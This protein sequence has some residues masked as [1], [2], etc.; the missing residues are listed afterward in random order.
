MLKILVIVGICVVLGF[1]GAIFGFF[2]RA[3]GS[4]ATDG[5]RFVSDPIEYTGGARQVTLEDGTVAY[6]PDVDQLEF[7]SEST[8]QTIGLGNPS[9]NTDLYFTI[10]LKLSGQQLLK[11]DLLHPGEGI[12]DEDLSAIFKPYT[13]SAEVVY[14]FYRHEDDGK[15]V[16]FTSISQPIIINVTGGTE[17]YDEQ[18]QQHMDQTTQSV[19]STVTTTTVDSNGN[20]VSSNTHQHTSYGGDTDTSTGGDSGSSDGESSDSGSSSDSAQ[21]SDS[22]TGQDSAG[23]N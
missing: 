13:Y 23:S 15:L 21:G 9:E 1:A 6:V 12:G 8:T 4:I 18:Y 11:T 20:V 16:Y 10:E 19:N 14:N 17:Y 7:T 22:S 5:T 2:G 3:T